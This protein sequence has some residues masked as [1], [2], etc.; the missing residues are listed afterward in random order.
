M[1]IIKIKSLC[2]GELLYTWGVLFIRAKA[3]ENSQF[4][5]FYCLEEKT[6]NDKSDSWLP[7][8]NTEVLGKSPQRRRSMMVT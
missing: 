5:Y 2:R 4:Q 1:V 7:L 3:E 6:M 8:S